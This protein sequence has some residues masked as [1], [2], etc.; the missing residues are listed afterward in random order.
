MMAKFIDQIRQSIRQYGYHAYLVSG[1]DI[2]RFAYA[3]GI[4]D[5]IGYEI[6]FGGGAYYSANDIFS[7]IGTLARGYLRGDEVGETSFSVD[8]VGGFSLQ[9]VHES[10]VHH[11]MLGAL[12]YYN[13]KTVS[14]VQV[15]PDEHHRTIDVPDMSREFSPCDEP[16]WRWVIEPWTFPAPSGTVA[17]T[18][19]EALRGRQVTEAGRWEADHWEIFAGPGPDVS[20]GDARAVPLG[21]LI[22]FDPSVASLL[23]LNVGEARWR[24]E[25]ETRWREWKAKPV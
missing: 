14:A 5:I 17:L 16:V 6:I 2:P 8:G 12:D 7:I 23:P 13:D 3:V 4:C 18:N 1:G 24:E 21:T 9:P 15:C 10:W 22:G 11:L 20:E 19:L 25:G